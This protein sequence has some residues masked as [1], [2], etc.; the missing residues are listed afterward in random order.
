[1]QLSEGV[2]FQLLVDAFGEAPSAEPIIE[3]QEEPKE[4]AKQLY[5]KQMLARQDA[6]IAAEKAKAARLIHEPIEEAVAPSKKKGKSKDGLFIKTG[7]GLLQGAIVKELDASSFVTL[8]VLSSFMD[9]KG[10]CY[11]GQDTLAEILGIKR[12]TVNRQINN[13]SRVHMRS[14]TY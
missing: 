12:E 8:M 1:M 5:V 3:V 2:D 13:K 10:E 6:R 11:A 9:N 14:A 7:I 4:T